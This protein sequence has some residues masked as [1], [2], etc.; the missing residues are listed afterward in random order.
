[1]NRKYTREEF[2]EIV[3]L[4]RKY[5]PLAGITTDIIA[6]FPTETEEDFNDTL[7]LI[8]TV[9]FSDI[10]PFIFSPR[11]GTPAYKMSDLPTEVKKSR[12]DR[13][14]EI[15]RRLKTDFAALMRGKI[16]EFLPEEFKDGYTEGYSENYLR[17]YIKGEIPIGEIVKVKVGG[18]FKD[19]ATAEII[20]E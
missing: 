16:A 9:R 17:L 7:S 13:L 10:H 8:D 12:L 2:I 4:I 14:L 18:A 3:D 5:F 20:K 15:K 19:G 6:G 11:S 1:M